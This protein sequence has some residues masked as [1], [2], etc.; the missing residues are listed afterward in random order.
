MTTLL[1]GPEREANASPRRRAHRTWIAITIAIVLILVAGGITATV[2]RYAGAQPLQCAC[3]FGWLSQA[4]A[5]AAVESQADGHSQTT[6]A[7]RLGQ[8]QGFFIWITNRSQVTQT[9]LGAPA[10]FFFGL[11]RL[12]TSVLVA[13]RGGNDVD[14]RHTEY[15]QRAT[16]AP[17]ATRWLK[18][19]WTNPTSCAGSQGS[20]TF[21]D[22]IPLRVRV[23]VLT[24]TENVA[25][26][27]AF[28]LVAKGC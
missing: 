4:D 23:G 21:I 20:T 28:G 10:D 1:I 16:L 18:V 22:S 19:V 13:T 5:S 11:T 3:G 8:Q 12:Q 7:A 2:E 26:A 25:M 15:A 14:P 6:V 27:S 17:G 9:I 24:R